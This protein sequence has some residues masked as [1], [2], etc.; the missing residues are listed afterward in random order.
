MPRK[1]KK[2]KKDDPSQRKLN[3]FLNLNHYVK[4]IEELTF[5]QLKNINLR[6]VGKKLRLIK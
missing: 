4:Q 5:K 2:E 6:N 3:D 1:R